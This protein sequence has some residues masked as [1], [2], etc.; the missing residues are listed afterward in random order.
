MSRVFR[1]LEDESMMAL[2]EALSIRSEALFKHAIGDK[3]LDDLRIEVLIFSIAGMTYLWRIF[4]L[5]SIVFREILSSLTV[6][7][8]SCCTS[9]MTFSKGEML[10]EGRG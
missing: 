3:S 10:H 5:D 8:K 6:S 4:D 7:M 9:L 2:V 1:F